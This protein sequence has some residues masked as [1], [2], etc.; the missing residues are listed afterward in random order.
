MTELT[1]EINGEPLLLGSSYVRLVGVVSGRQKVALV[2][3][4][5]R[6]RVICAGSG[7]NGYEVASI[8]K[9]SVE[10]VKKGVMTK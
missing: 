10:L 2:E 4:G 7:F 5:G 3:I 8:Y 9:D 1:L 6:G